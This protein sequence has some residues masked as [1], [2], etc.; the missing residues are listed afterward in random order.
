MAIQNVHQIE[1]ETDQ[2]ED[3]IKS[4]ISQDFKM[5]TG[6]GKTIQY[7]IVLKIPYLTGRPKWQILR[8]QAPKAT[9]WIHELSGRTKDLIQLK[10]AFQRRINIDN[11][12]LPDNIWTWERYI[13]WLGQ[14]KD[15]SDTQW[16]YAV[17]RFKA[18]MSIHTN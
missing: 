11:N 4:E 2:I 16:A 12:N 15:I 3:F 5:N 13:N 8:Q 18:F 14:D 7:K 1:Q 17:K 10:D 6:V 9:K